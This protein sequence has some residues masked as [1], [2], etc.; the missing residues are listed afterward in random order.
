MR[1]LAARFSQRPSV[2]TCLRSSWLA[3]PTRYPEFSSPS[4][5]LGS[6]PPSSSGPCIN[7]QVWLHRSLDPGRPSRSSAP[8]FLSFST[9]CHVARLSLATFTLDSHRCLISTCFPPYIYNKNL[10]PLG[11]VMLSFYFFFSFSLQMRLQ[12]QASNPL[13]LLGVRQISYS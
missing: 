11:A 6:P 7:H 4:T 2:P 3:Y 13:S 12:S 10:S 8:L 9:S 1:K 5:G